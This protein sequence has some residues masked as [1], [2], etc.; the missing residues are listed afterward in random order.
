M[1]Y[2]KQLDGLRAIAVILVIISHW[3]PTTN[4]I[5]RIPNGAIGVD[6]FFVL[7]G[8]LI[9]KILFDNKNR[10]EELNI[11]KST[12]IKNFY[13]RRTLRIFP[14]Y[15]LTIF[16]LL[17]FS[18]YTGTNIQSAFVY[19]LTYTSNFYFFDIQGWDG[20]VSHLWSLAVEEQFYLIWP[21][22]IL[23]SN[24]KYFLHI[25]SIF[26]FIG[27]LSQYLMSGVKMSSVLTFTCFDAFGLGA[28]LSWIITYAPDKLKR[29]YVIISV[30]SAISFF[31]FIVGA[32]QNK[33]TV[34]PFRT[35]VSFITLWIITYIIINRET[36]SLKFKFI[37]NNRVLIFLGKISYG[38][39]LYHNIIPTLN[40]KIINIYINPLL[41]DILYKKYWGQLYLLENSILLV[42]ISW[43]SFILIEKR[44]LNLKKYFDYQKDNSVQQK[45]LQKQGLTM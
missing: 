1:K 20:M 44:F 14:I 37:L 32:I 26:I 39:Y 22:V 40:S 29:F 36:N 21:W 12:S 10:A 16:I 25:I 17:L 23:F 41:P 30:V 35:L 34:I 11:P 19:F 28:F 24:K 18:K 2:I 38:L 8:F 13:V 43:L 33:W 6:I 3:I 45:Y 9:S 7:S 4:L 31:L 27:V 5:N 15:Y 42:A